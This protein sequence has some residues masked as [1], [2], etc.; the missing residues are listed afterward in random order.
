MALASVGT[1]ER[2][3]AVKLDGKRVIV[4]GG[5]KGIGA[6]AVRAFVREG[7][8]VAS[9]DVL[10]D[11]GREVA[12]LATEEG[13]GRALF[14]HC[15]VRH[16]DEVRDAFALSVN[17][18]G[19]LDSLVHAAGVERASPADATTDEEW[20][21]IMD[22]NLRGTFLTNQEAFPY[23]RDRGG[24][25]VNF[26]SG[27][28]MVPYPGGAHYSASKAGVAAWTRT[29]AH[30]WGRY[31]ITA[32]ALAPAMWTP[33]YDEHRARLSAEGQLEAHDAHMT[34]M[35]PVGGRLG[36]PDTDLA[37]TLVFLLGDG[38]RFITAQTIAVEGGMI[39]V[40]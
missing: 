24:R 33:M 34:A 25:I 22:V 35:I 20:D 30:E 15:D 18:L 10:D 17:D 9:L 38:A 4:T 23:L 19:G 13:P 40:R 37:P 31:G 8:M 5:A 29:I 12:R 39:P 11:P 26:G 14:I 28:A 6:S 7:A 1:R 16:R 21:L 3:V 27:A 32:N 36:D 2:K